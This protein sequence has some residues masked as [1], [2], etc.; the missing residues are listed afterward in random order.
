MRTQLL[1]L[2]ALSAL[3]ACAERASETVIADPTP[4]IID[5]LRN[6]AEVG[7]V[8]IGSQPSAEVLEY[9]AA[10]GYET[11]VSTRAPEEIDWDEAAV[12]EELGMRFV[13]IP[14]PGPVEAISDEQ[15]AAFAAVMETGEGR[16]LLHCG[17][18]NR[19]AGLWGAWLAEYKDI[20]PAEALRLAELGGMT[21]VRPVV[22][23]RLGAVAEE[24]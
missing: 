12:V 1:T 18:G 13:N 5:G 20:D 15:L 19:V 22:E 10:Q 4:C 6:C 23:Q 11:I 7:N 21:R 8:V 3:L 2:L 17:S 24:R 16:M 9:L 14:M